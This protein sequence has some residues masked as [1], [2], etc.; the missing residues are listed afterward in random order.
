MWECGVVW[1]E[2][3]WLG[4]EVT[5][6]AAEIFSSVNTITTPIQ[7]R[8]NLVLYDV[9]AEH[10]EEA[11]EKNSRKKQSEEATAEASE[12]AEAEASAVLLLQFH[13]QIFSTH[14]QQHFQHFNSNSF[15]PTMT[16]KT[17][18]KTNIDTYAEK[19]ITSQ[20]SMHFKL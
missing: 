18:R 8:L 20:K 10:T 5:L 13:F 7:Q 11:E 2:R 16:A 9:E 6:L 12:Q 15:N 4:D 1:F 19:V 17:N 14:F 3:R